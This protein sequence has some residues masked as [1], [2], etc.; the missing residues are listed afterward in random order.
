MNDEYFSTIA[1]ATAFL[2]H[3][4]RVCEHLPQRGDQGRHRTLRNGFLLGETTRPSVVLLG[5]SVSKLRSS[6]RKYSK[7]ITAE[8]AGT[9]L[10]A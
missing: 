6:R 2:L 9:S 7:L 5:A 10:F 8:S 1:A 4:V 3:L